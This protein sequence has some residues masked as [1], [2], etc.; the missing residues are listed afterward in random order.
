V[1]RWLKIFPRPRALF[2]S[3]AAV[4]LLIDQTTKHWI[5]THMFIG[6]SIKV[7]DHFFYITYLQNEGVAFGFFG[8]AGNALVGFLAFA[9]LLLGFWWTRDLDWKGREANIIGAMI[10]AGAVGN[11]IDRVRIGAVIDFLEFFLHFGPWR[12]EWPS[13]NV[14]DSCISS[15]V[16]YIIARILTSGWIDSSRQKTKVKHD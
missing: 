9:I 7:I 14:A 13:F 2:W 3:I 4:I 1:T 11:L 16:I 12:Y 10:F 15:S 5:E 8:H 6:Q